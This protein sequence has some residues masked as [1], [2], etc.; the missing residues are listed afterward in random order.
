MSGKDPEEKVHLPMALQG[1]RD[2]SLLHWSVPSSSV[3][4]LLPAPLRP[5]TWE[6]AAWVSMT[7][8]WAVH[9]RLPMT[10]AVPRVSNY[11]ETNVRTYVIGPDGRDG[12]FFLALET[13]NPMALAARSLGVSYNVAAMSF[14]RHDGALRYRSTRRFPRPA[15]RHDIVIRPGPALDEEDALSYWLAG[16]W[17]AWT[18]VAGRWAAIP[19]EH[20]PWPL[21]SATAEQMDETLLSACGLPDAGSP[22]LVHYAPS[23]D[24]KLGRPQ[25]VRS[26]DS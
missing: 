6:G 24:V 11:H 5:D 13:D 12:L 15:A 17:R 20:E 18:H 19:V 8:F 2:I 21:H 1:W 9:S 25:V 16:R 3:Q 4:A 22:E 26:R 23:L 7:P 10:L 14:D